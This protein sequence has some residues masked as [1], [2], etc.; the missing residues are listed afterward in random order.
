MIARLDVQ[1]HERAARIIGDVADRGECD[2]VREV[3][4]QLPMH[5]IADIVG[6][7][8]P[9]RPRVFSLTDTLMRAADP[10]SGLTM[11]DH[12]AAELE[13]YQYAHELGQEKRRHPADDVWSILAVAEITDE[14]GEPSRLTEVE[15]DIFF[16]IL[17]IAGS[18]TTRNA[19][20]QGL[21]ALIERPDQLAALRTRPD[22]LD[23]A[24]DEMIRW[25]SP[26]TQFG[27]TAMRDV[28]LG[29]QQIATGDRVTLWYASANRDE[30]AFDDPFRFDVARH[31]NPHVSFGGGG[32]HYC[33]G[34][35]LA[36]RE[37]RTI[38]EQLLAR[39]ATIEQTGPP[40]W[41][42]SGPD[43]S[44][45]FSVDRLPVRLS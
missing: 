27:R 12:R 26:V 4:Y 18:E 20:A 10:S 43:Q 42:V 33:L 41:S 40:T 23:T 2:F 24:T 29:G 15:H 36:K 8:E 21:M 11:D 34:A 6:I 1:I 35:H 9:D 38:F 7:P 22:L 13:L 31:P 16:S 45:G 19:I 44:V 5:V 25:A 30:K 28:E 32:V 17:A 3:A 37:I 14:A 39:F